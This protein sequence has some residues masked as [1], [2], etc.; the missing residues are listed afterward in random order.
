MVTT[1]N[2]LAQKAIDQF[3]H[4]TALKKL[5]LDHLDVLN[6]VGDTFVNARKWKF[7]KG[8][9]G[10][11]AGRGNIS[12]TT[13]T[14]TEASLT[15]TST[16]SFANYSFIDEDQVKI[17]GGTSVTEK[18][19]TIASR[20]SDNAIVLTESL[21]TTGGDLAAA[22]IAGVLHLPTMELPPNFGTLQ[23]IA[24]STSLVNSI[25]MVDS[26]EIALLRGQWDREDDTG[27]YR[28]AIILVGTPPRPVLDVHPDFST[29]NEDVFRIYYT[30]NWTRVTQA[31]STLPIPRYCNAAFMQLCRHFALGWEDEDIRGLE[32]RIEVWKNGELFKGAAAQDGGQQFVYGRMRGGSVR[33]SPYKVFPN[34]L[35]NEVA[36]PS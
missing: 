2:I 1:N 10:F 7:L 36:G 28:G 6:M 5:G 25:G 26:T 27:F 23:S 35:S 22:D 17:T 31:S 33:R 11:L 9:N 34:S 32:E 21:S 20:T 14:W 3:L 8:A 4:S 24:G 12:L 29:N 18:Y 16:G 19:F 13:A 15:L 30:K